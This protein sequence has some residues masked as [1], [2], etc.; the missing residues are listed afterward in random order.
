MNG[1][2]PAR[3]ELC[4]AGLLLDGK[5]LALWSGSIHYFRMDPHDWKP[6]LVA[7]RDLGARLVE[8]YVPWSVHETGD[9]TFDFGEGDRRLDVVRFLRTASKV[10]LY[11]VVRPG[12]H[13]NA[14]LSDFGIPE[15]VLWDPACQAR[16]PRGNAVVLPLLPTSFPV[17]SYAS[18][19]FLL[20]V[21]RWYGEVGRRLAPLVYPEGPI[22]LCQIDNEGVL[23]FRDALL[24]QDYR[25]EA[26]ARFRT[27]LT[28]KHGPEAD[29]DA[30][31]PP[32]P[33]DPPSLERCLD[34][35]ELQEEIVAT[36]L[37]RMNAAWLGAGMDGVPTMHNFPM[38]HEASPLSI[39]RIGREVSFVALDYYGYA[40][41]RDLWLVER[42]TTE[43]ASWAEE[44][45]VPAFASEMGVGF[46]PYFPPR[47][48]RDDRFTTL[49]ALAYGLRGANFYMA[50][51]RDRWIGAPLDRRG[52]RLASS[53]FYERLLS[54]VGMSGFADLRRR[55][56]V[57]LVVSAMHRRL[58]RARSALGPVPP[59][60]LAARGLGAR[61]TCIDD[62]PGTVGPLGVDDAAIRVTAALTRAGVA[63]AWTEADK[64][65]FAAAGALWIIA[66]LPSG[67]HPATVE[68]LDALGRSGVRVSVLGRPDDPD[69]VPAGALDA[70]VS[71]AVRTLELPSRPAGAEGVHM[72]VHEDGNGSP[73]IAFLANP[74]DQPIVAKPE[75]PG[76]RLSDLIDRVTFDRRGGRFLVPLEPRS[77][78]MLAIDLA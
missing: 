71:E 9:G 46:P 5:P 1:K 25:P 47:T 13:V 21:E 24:D 14:E 19:A 52:K 54:A 56:P 63:F 26:L 51:D 43:L 65:D 40:T 31:A 48:E 20:E 57:R 36:A 60:L 69:D 66:L 59:V 12:P 76:Q 10:G 75:L 49:A 3:V 45:K 62:E 55:T 58:L 11:A 32:R 78:R 2:E 27:F 17:P 16:S 42:R 41:E 44:R 61:E 35:A 37:G 18:E 7:L 72:T 15:R 23:Y 70:W 8:T 39:G 74:G 38:G 30:L 77:I 67:A 53:W 4:R 33:D 29:P 34:W 50:V 73:R 68:R 28:D 64:G 22:V 6:A